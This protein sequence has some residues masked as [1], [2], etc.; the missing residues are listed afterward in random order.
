MSARDYDIVVI[1][2]GM[3]GAA[4]ACAMRGSGL[5]LGIVESRPPL[6]DW[7]SDSVDLRVSAISAASQQTFTA[8]GAWDRMISLGVSPFR[9]M[10]VWDAA[11]AGTIHFDSADI[12]ESRLG[13]IIENRV[14]QRALYECLTETA[15]V[16]L[17]CPMRIDALQCT[18]DE[19][20]VVLDDQTRLTSRLV[21]AAD[22]GQSRTRELAGIETTGEPYGQHAVVTYVRT[23]ES[24]RSTA[25]QRF[26]PTGP[27]AFLPLRDGSCSIVWST[28]PSHAE[29]LLDMDEGNFCAT[30]GTAFDQKLGQV[31]S[32]GPRA[33]FVLQRRHAVRYVQP[34]L[35]LVGDAAHTIHPLA[36]QGVNLG[37]LDAAALAEVLLSEAR[38]G[39]DV[40]AWRVL[41]RYERWRRGENQRMMSTMDIL[42]HLFESQRQPVAWLRNAGLAA[43]DVAWPIKRVLM[44]HA[45]GLSGDLPQLARPSCP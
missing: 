44:R 24:H 2:A 29:E 23:R 11:G 39:G 15:H 6:L 1:G 17:L 10:Y 20:A 5:R 8:L 13:H 12:A 30:L 4:F 45:M 41:R 27:L 42:K 31:Y 37:L 22:G 21:V 26:L 36:G 40:G 35:A 32:C 14:I 9:E 18:Q 7:P 43:T 38:H 25:W 28:T 34:R 3:V 16:D 19:A 33:A